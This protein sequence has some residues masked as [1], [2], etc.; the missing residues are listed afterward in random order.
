MRCLLITAGWYQGSCL[1]NPFSLSFLAISIIFMRLEMKQKLCTWHSSRCFPYFNLVHYCKNPIKIFYFPHPM[2]NLG[3][4][5]L[6]HLLKVTEPVDVRVKV[7][8]H[9]HQ[10]QCLQ[11]SHYTAFRLV[12]LC[13]LCIR[14]NGSEVRRPLTHTAFLI[15]NMLSAC[16]GTY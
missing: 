10:C 11:Q 4:P 5:S 8:F 9:L 2:L 7:C 15:F 14:I 16:S 1:Q 6:S 13:L 3:E 12:R